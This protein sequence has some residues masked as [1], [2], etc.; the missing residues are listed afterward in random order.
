MSNTDLS[1]LDSRF[2]TAISDDVITENEAQGL[3]KDLKQVQNES[4]DI[5]DA[6]NKYNI[7]TAKTDYQNAL[8]D[9]E[10]ELTT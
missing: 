3:K 6:A 7:T 4:T 9:L 2:T 5:I 8:S 10:T 1:N